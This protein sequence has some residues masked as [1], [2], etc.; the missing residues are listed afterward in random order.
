M[1]GIM[2]DFTPGRR[3][4]GV[5]TPDIEDNYNHL[6]SGLYILQGAPVDRSYK[7]VITFANVDAQK[8]FF[9]QY[10]QTPDPS[11][12]LPLS[13][14]PN[15]YDPMLWIKD[16]QVIIPGNANYIRGANYMM[17]FNSSYYGTNPP[18][19]TT[20]DGSTVVHRTQGKWIYAFIDDVV[21]NA[22]LSTT[23]YY[24]IDYYQTYQFDF[25]FQPCFVER[26]TQQ[27]AD[28]IGANLIDENLALGPYVEDP[29]CFED[30]KPT[31]WWVVVGST[32]NLEDSA[33]SDAAGMPYFHVYSGVYYYC[34]NL[35]TYQT[36]QDKLLELATAGKADAI[37]SMHMVPKTVLASS[38]LHGKQLVSTYVT[39]WITPTNP[40]SPKMPFGTYT[41]K[42]NKLYTYPYHALHVSNHMG[43]SI[44]Y[45]YEFM[46][47][48]L[49][50]GVAELRINYKGSPMPDGKI[51]FWPVY[52]NGM[53]NQLDYSISVGDYPQC[54]WNKDVYANWLATQQVRWDRQGERRRMQATHNM[55]IAAENMA[56]NTA[57]GLVSGGPGKAAGA[58]IGGVKNLIQTGQGNQ[59]AE[60]LARSVMAEESEIFD[61]APPSAQGTVGNG[62]TLIA[63]DQWGITAVRVHITEDYARSI[64][65]YLWAYGYAQRRILQPLPRRHQNWDYYKTTGAIVV[66]NA[67]QPAR[68][69]MQN[70]LNSGV[71][72]WNA[73]IPGNFNQANGLMG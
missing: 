34:Y 27:T 39:K 65:S 47:P 23:I 36:L 53:L 4:L 70:M 59:L 41:P 21:Y 6:G 18:G 25:F 52:Y 61:M 24:T 63:L 72:F 29:D 68:E 58:A 44:D 33:F 9:Q 66:G 50:E 5:D 30:L 22:D 43:Q 55:T 64:D 31:D 62:S 17:F 35:Q 16:G 13:P 42:C 37:V 32:V 8:A 2:G 46:T 73:Q 26:C 28:T 48:V 3:D 10:I 20:S 11:A 57:A 60:D 54:S 71:R 40:N 15:F 56:Y 67:P 12:P 19:D 14:S 45:R 38:Q 51:I 1:A 69:L 7:N 49:N